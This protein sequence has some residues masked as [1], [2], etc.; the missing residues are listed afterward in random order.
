MTAQQGSVFPRTTLSGII[1]PLQNVGIT[2]SLTEPTDAVYVKEGDHVRAGQLLAL[3]DTADLRATLAADL[4]TANSNQAKATQTYDQAGLTISQNSNTVNAA[5][6]AVRQAQ[7][8]LSTDTLN[9][10][11]DAMLLR[12]GYI[13]Q[14]AYDQQAT[15]VKNDQQLLRSA[16]VTLQNDIS[17]VRANGTVSSGLQ[18]AQVASAR[19]DTQMALAQADQVRVQIAK[20]RIVSPIDAVVVNRNLNPGEFPGTRQIFTL[21]ETDRVYAVLNG[22]ASQIVG[23][24]NG[25]TVNVQSG[26]L[27][28]KQFSG[29]VEGV[30]NAINPGSTNFVVKVVL[31]NAGGT[32]RPG[33]AVSGIASLPSASGVRI[34]ATAFLDTTNSTVQTVNN[35][36]VHTVKVTMLAQDAQNAIVSGLPPGASVVTNGQL[37]LSDGQAVQPQLQV[38]E[39]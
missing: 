1:A 9:L 10:Q 5:R 26:N 19:A 25:A 8:T 34:P 37:G 20:A 39:K 32:L 12:N 27:P 14:Q 30:L 4:A 3:L 16:Q 15:T 17:Q 21:Q 29:K 38:A 31:A 2:S 35:G 13:A 23:I 22:A 28:G 18:G 24:A 11:R 36:V 6:A 33:M 7:Q